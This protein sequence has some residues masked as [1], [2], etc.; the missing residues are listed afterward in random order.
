MSHQIMVHCGA[1]VTR[2]GGVGGAGG[3]L[4]AMGI[5]GE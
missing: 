5:V 1:L 2:L 3:G 4:E